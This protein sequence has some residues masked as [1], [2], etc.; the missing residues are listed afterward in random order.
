MVKVE[1]AIVTNVTDVSDA[2]KSAPALFAQ[3]HDVYEVKYNSTR[4][5][6]T[7]SV[8]ATADMIDA[9]IEIMYMTQ[10]SC[11]TDKWHKLPNPTASV[12]DALVYTQTKIRAGKGMEAYIKELSDMNSSDRY[13]TEEPVSRNEQS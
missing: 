5:N 8:Y 10:R 7:E 11:S 4:K 6:D 3:G 12:Y 1:D 9:F 13:T 2:P